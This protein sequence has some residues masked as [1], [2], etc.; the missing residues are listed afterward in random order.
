MQ[1]LAL[2]AR[3][4]FSLVFIVSSFGHFSPATIRHAAEHGVPFAPIVVPIAG[5]IA[6]AGGLSVL[7]GWQARVGAWLLVL[8]LV[9]VTLFMHNFWAVHDP[10][11]HQ[12][13]R[14]EFLKNLSLLG[15]ALLVAYF[16]SGPVS[17]DERL[18]RRHFWLPRHA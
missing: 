9:P 13:Q 16:G 2:P 5:V 10:L 4:L 11:Q 7:F 3:A 15:G 18:P 17:L 12:L 1:Y 6:L 8:F 14:V